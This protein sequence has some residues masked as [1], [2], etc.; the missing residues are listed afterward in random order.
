MGLV[1]SRRHRSLS[2]LGILAAESKYPGY[3]SNEQG[4]P[5]PTSQ[6]GDVTYVVPSR[7]KR[8][9][10]KPVLKYFDGSWSLRKR[11][12]GTMDMV[13]DKDVN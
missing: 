11:E 6:L 12:S 1:Q 13:C 5:S 2:W 10:V 8:L 3:N 9:E 7:N 4:H